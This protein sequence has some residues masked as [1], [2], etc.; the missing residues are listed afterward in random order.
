M[1]DRAGAILKL[2]AALA[3]LI[4]GSG[5]GYYYG[6]FLPDHARD[7]AEYRVSRADAAER[8]RR[9]AE[10]RS[11]AEEARRQQAAEMAY[12]DC[13]NF[14]EL[15]YKNRWAASCRAMH[16]RDLAE[17]EDCRDDFFSTEGSCR[18]RHPIR[19]ERGCALPSQLAATF[20][21]DRD[22]AKEQCL[23]QLQ[24]SRTAG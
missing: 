8:A 24:A 20:V 12:E 6:I 1:L 9:D 17:F 19:P 15:N 11:A 10:A 18:R 16:R 4:A 5:I 21:E 7:Q 2:C 22:R 13:L 14:A 3:L 23:G